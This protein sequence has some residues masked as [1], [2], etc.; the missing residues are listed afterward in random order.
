MELALEALTTIE[1]VS[2]TRSINNNGHNWRVTFLSQLGDLASMIADDSQ[3]AGPN[4]KARVTTAKNGVTPPGY[5]SMQLTDP[6]ATQYT[7][8]GLTMGTS[9]LVHVKAYN[10]EGF[11][12]FGLGPAPLA[13]VEA[14][15]APQNVQF[16]PLSLSALKVTWDAPAS[17][18]GKGIVKYLIEWDV[19]ENFAEPRHFRVQARASSGFYGRPDLLLQHPNSRGLGTGEALRPRDGLQH[20]RVELPRFARDQV[21]HWRA[22][23]AGVCA[24]AYAERNQR[25]WAA[26]GVVSA[27]GGPRG[28]RWRRWHAH[29]RVLH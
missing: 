12:T 27:I 11:G 23:S 18:G 13:P 9:Y 17:T 16:F 4:A 2:V 25:G 14:P 26:R 24:V 10:A 6:T 15:S 28:L 7:I 22:Q 20:V 5:N 1:D 29:Y 19:E 21:C 8:T 3:L